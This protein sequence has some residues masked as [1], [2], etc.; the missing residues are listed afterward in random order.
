M[1][2]Y[3]KKI[4]LILILSLLVVGFL[5]SAN[6]SLAQSENESADEDELVLPQPIEGDIPTIVGRVIKY[7]L[8]MVGI[9]ALIM[10]IIA[11]IAWMTSGGAQEK[12]SKA[13][14]TILWTLIGLVFIFLSYA[15][16]EFVLKALMNK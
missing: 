11:G 8:G 4:G 1:I 14:N 2:K 13:K 6:I 9:L 15:I 12:I 16:L 3:K 5:L 10:F 7:V